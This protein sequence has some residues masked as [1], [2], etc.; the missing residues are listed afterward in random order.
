MEFVGSGLEGD[1][2]DGA[3]GAAQ[4]SLEVVGGDV[5][6]GNGFCRRNHDLQQAGALVVVDTFNLVEV[7]D[8]RHAVGFGLQGAGS[9]E[10]L[11]VL[12]DRGSGAGNYVEEGLVVAVGAQRHVDHG[13]RLELGAD[14]GAIRLELRGLGGYCNALIDAAEGKSEINTDCRVAEQVDIFLGHFLETLD[15]DGYQ[16]VA[17]LQVRKGVVA[18]FIGRRRV[19]GAG[20]HICCGNFGVGNGSAGGVCHCSQQGSVY[21]LAKQGV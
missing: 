8:A 11:R 4:L 17:G 10:E 6:G 14:V 16:I 7:A 2:D 21:G 1:V 12:E 15:F 13:L 20:G 5:D 9:V 19:S 3:D 18:A